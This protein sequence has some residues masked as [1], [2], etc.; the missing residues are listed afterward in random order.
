VCRFDRISDDDDAHGALIFESFRARL[1]AQQTAMANRALCVGINDYPG[2]AMDLAGCVNDAR[3]WQALFEQRGYRVDPLHDSEATRARIVE[4]LRAVIGQ[5]G[6]DDSVVFTFSGHGSWLPDDNRDEPDARDEMMCPH[7][8]MNGQYLFDDELH[9]IFCT[10][11]AGARLYVIADCCH[12][13][14]VVRYAS[15]A[16]PP[17]GM[18]LKARFLP[19][20]VFARGDRVLERA[21][22]RAVNTPAPAKLRYP[23]LLFSGCQDTEFSYDTSFDRRPNGAFTRT[24]IDALQDAT[25][26]SPRALYDAIRMR[27]PSPALPQ[28]PQ[29]FGSPEAQL[30]RL[31]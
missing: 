10:K 8:V 22:D 7:D 9:E 29:L 27:L 19:P 12:S 31:F 20:Y 13:G 3:D 18:P 17:G 6:E 24:A 5:A 15:P 30:G 2:A 21:I 4:A 28:T 11:R 23:A 14:S 26:L 16:A 25:I 1:P